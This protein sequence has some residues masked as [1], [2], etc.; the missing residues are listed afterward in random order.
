MSICI[1]A[2]A[3]YLFSFSLLRTLSPSYLKIS[4]LPEPPRPD[5]LNTCGLT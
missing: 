3:L 5:D 1:Q 4:A 2:Q